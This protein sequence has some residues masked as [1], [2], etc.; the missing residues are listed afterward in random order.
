MRSMLSLAFKLLLL[1]LRLLLLLLL[2]SLQKR[3]LLGNAAKPQEGSKHFQHRISMAVSHAIA[4]EFLQRFDAVLWGFCAKSL[5]QRREHKLPHNRQGG[6]TLHLITRDA[7]TPDAALLARLFKRPQQPC[8]AE[9]SRTPQVINARAASH[10]RLG[11]ELREA[12]QV[13]GP[14]NQG[15]GFS[16]PQLC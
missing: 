8:F 10:P 5:I 14:A 7:D 9:P 12:A 11:H 2:V 3:W 6:V 13:W 15:L 1:L 4:H 16:H